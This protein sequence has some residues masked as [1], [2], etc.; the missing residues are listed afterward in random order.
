M[1]RIKGKS[2]QMIIAT[3]V[4][5]SAIATGTLPAWSAESGKTSQTVTM[6]NPVEQGSPQ[7][8]SQM[9]KIIAKISTVYP[10]FKQLQLQSKVY[11]REVPNYLK[12][13]GHE[14]TWEWTYGEQGVA[15]E[16]GKDDS[17]IPSNQAV[18]VLDGKEGSLI[19][20]EWNSPPWQKESLHA[21]TW[22]LA[23]AKAS[24][25]LQG[26]GMPVQEYQ[27]REF[28]ENNQMKMIEFHRLYNG[29]PLLESTYSVAVDGTG[30]VFGFHSDGRN[31]FDAKDFPNPIEAISAEAAKKVF[32]DNLAVNLQYVPQELIDLMQQKSLPSTLPIMGRK[33]F[34]PVYV[35]NYPGSIDAITGKATTAHLEDGKPNEQVVHIQGKGQVLT[36]PTA[37]KGLQVLAREFGLNIEGLEENRSIDVRREE[38]TQP[39]RQRYFWTSKSEKNGGEQGEKE[40][41]LSISLTIESD[42]GRIVGFSA[43]GKPTDSSRITSFPVEKA[44]AKALDVIGRYIPKG[45]YDMELTDLSDP[46]I[47]KHPEWVD[48]DKIPKHILD[49]N[50][51]T[52][53][54]TLIHQGIPVESMNASISLDKYTGQVTSLLLSLPELSK[55]P[56]VMNI[57][58]KEVAKKAALDNCHLEMYYTWPE[59]LGQWAPKPSLIYRPDWIM[60]GGI[61]DAFTGTMI[62]QN[63]KGE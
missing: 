31:N 13:N 9:G 62:H 3:G 48:T 23:K 38:N 43:Y 59:Y 40:D 32:S 55:L 10:E 14:S 4:V 26:L 37:A 36:A 60:T 44:R 11:H 17:A 33:T 18:F 7:V 54:F 58:S 19:S 12:F 22:D 49:V 21:P 42:T 46:S 53:G 61:V 30:R 45:N 34:H 15:E 51:Y 5:L 47:F 41:E 52:Y 57:V 6:A 25:F 29:I 24:E 63:D 20:F 8:E 39:H 2:A 27:A 16:G 28:F 56:D 1:D 35:L 50:N